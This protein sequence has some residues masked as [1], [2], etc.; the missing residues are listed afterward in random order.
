MVQ[1]AGIV[2]G[3]SKDCNGLNK[4][5]VILDKFHYFFGVVGLKEFKV[6]FA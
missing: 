5:T 4:L 3:W 1:Y 6:E 2:R